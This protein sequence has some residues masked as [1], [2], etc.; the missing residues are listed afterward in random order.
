[1]CRF[2]CVC[3]TPIRQPNFAQPVRHILPLPSLESGPTDFCLLG[4]WLR[5]VPLPTFFL[6]S[7][8]PLP[9]LGLLFG[10]CSLYCTCFGYISLLTPHFLSYLLPRHF[11]CSFLVLF[12]FALR[13]M[14]FLS[15]LSFAPLFSSPHLNWPSLIPI[16]HSLYRPSLMFLSLAP[17]YPP[18][19]SHT[20]SPSVAISSL[21]SWLHKKVPITQ[22]I[23]ILTQTRNPEEEKKERKKPSYQK[24]L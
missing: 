2:L 16:L 17:L 18:L 12:R 20:R 15:R 14:T 22:N 13:T 21:S 4:L 8:S 10:S 23:G 11:P 6:G 19:C 3:F 1:M 5:F 7:G 24:S 9:V